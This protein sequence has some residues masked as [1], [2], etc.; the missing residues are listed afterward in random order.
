[1]YWPLE[2]L[3]GVEDVAGVEPWDVGGAADAAALAADSALRPT[4]LATG[5]VVEAALR[6]DELLLPVIPVQVV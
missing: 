6:Y 5:R 2:R 3:D 1:M 4:E